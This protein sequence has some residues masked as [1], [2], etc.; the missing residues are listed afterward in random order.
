MA[1][2]AVELIKNAEQK[3]YEI[4]SRAKDDARKMK[5][6]AMNKKHSVIENGLSEAGIEV[7][8]RE[9][10]IQKVC[11]EKI[12]SEIEAYLKENEPVFSGMEKKLDETAHKIVSEIFM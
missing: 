7:A 12:Q 8:K 3:A 11:S 1:K 2:D 4:V 10:D 5:E 9:R 6:E